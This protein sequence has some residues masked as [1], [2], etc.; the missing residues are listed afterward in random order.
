MQKVAKVGSFACYLS[1]KNKEPSQGNCDA[2]FR[3][4]QKVVVKGTMINEGLKFKAQ[5]VY[6]CI[7]CDK[8][9]QLRITI[10]FPNNETDNK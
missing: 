4:Q 8:P 2:V 3:N 1:F 6:L 7:E 5:F 10:K 9:I